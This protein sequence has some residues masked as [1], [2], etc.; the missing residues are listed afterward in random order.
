MCIIYILA[1]ISLLITFSLFRQFFGT[2]D[3]FAAFDKMFQ[4]MGGSFGDDLC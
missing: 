2:N 1:A 3:V 4:E